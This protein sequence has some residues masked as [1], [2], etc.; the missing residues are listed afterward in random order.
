MPNRKESQ[1][2]RPPLRP[3]VTEPPKSR[4]R[5]GRACDRCKVKKSK[6]DGNVP[7]ST[8]T[9]SDSTC[10]YSARRRREAR[11]WYW[12]M[13]DIIDEALQRLYWACREGTGFPGVVPD[14]SSGRVSTD[15][16][17]RGLGL[18]PPRVDNQRPSGSR[19]ESMMDTQTQLLLPRSYHPP[20]IRPQPPVSSQNLTTP[21]TMTPLSTTSDD[22]HVFGERMLDV[23]L[24]RHNT[25]MMEVDGEEDDGLGQEL[26]DGM[27]AGID[28]TMLRGGH[29]G[30][31]DGSTYASLD[32]LPF[33]TA[34]PM[35][36]QG[37]KMPAQSV[38]QFSVPTLGQQRLQSVTQS[39]GTME[40]Q[41]WQGRHDQKSD[42]L[43][44]WPG[45]MAS[46]HPQGKAEDG[47]RGFDK[48]PDG[49]R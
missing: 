21:S 10:E 6:C 30:S 15:A 33:G 24:G 18:S 20:D 22:R 13:Q 17:L 44:P 7:C 31:I 36:S 9:L 39:L 41:V 28:P 48:A 29:A 5:I 23:G 14:E 4:M 42:G 2:G 12:G 26:Q 8:C 16:I 43:L 19:S 46:M 38:N 47:G 32:A 35:G 34:V 11:D 3:G 25:S 27:D 49:E 1:E 37:R 45:N 40:Q